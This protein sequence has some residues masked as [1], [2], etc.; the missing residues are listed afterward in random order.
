MTHL[1]S[2][3]DPSPYVAA[4]E[5]GGK[6]VT[7]TI[8]RVVRAEVIGEGGKK[9]KKPVMYF[10]DWDKP[11]VFGKTVAKT[12]MSLYGADYENLPGKRITMYT[13]KEKNHEG[14]M[15][16]RVRVRRKVPAANVAM[17]TLSERA[18]RLEA[19][20]SAAESTES[21]R[22]VWDSAIKLR[23]ALAAADKPL[24][25]TLTDT[26]DKRAIVLGEKEEAL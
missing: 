20:I 24:L 3:F 18:A 25:A 6:D 15:E 26:Y 10:R 19:A 23:D 17:P 8:D 21:L 22:S 7:V 5:L 16:D 14:E 2:L 9:S 12:L 4:W 11:M 13:V 1:L